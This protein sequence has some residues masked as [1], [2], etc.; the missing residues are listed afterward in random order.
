M[1]TIRVLLTWATS[2]VKHWL[3]IQTRVLKRQHPSA[4][5]QGVAQELPLQKHLTGLTWAGLT[6]TLWLSTQ[7]ILPMPRPALTQLRERSIIFSLSA[8]PFKDFWRMVLTAMT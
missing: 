1:E 2:R 3:Q 6:A 7:G 5:L 4:E 8:V